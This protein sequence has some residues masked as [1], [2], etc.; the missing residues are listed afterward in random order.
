[1]GFFQIQQLYSC[2]LTEK[3]SPNFLEV[4]PQNLTVNPNYKKDP[5]SGT[6]ERF[7]LFAE[8]ELISAQDTI[9]DEM[10]KVL[11][12]QIG[13]VK[14]SESQ[15][16]N[17]CAKRLKKIIEENWKP[18]KNH[19][20]MHSS[21][22][23]SRIISA[24][25]TEFFRKYGP[26]WLGKTIF[27]CSSKEGSAFKRIMKLEGWDLNQY[28]TIGNNK[29]RETI[30]SILLDFPNAWRRCNGT[31]LNP[32]NPFVFFPEAAH[33]SRRFP[34]ENIQSWTGLGANELFEHFARLNL[35]I[36]PSAEAVFERAYYSP[37]VASR[38]IIGEVIKPFS[39]T[40]LLSLAIQSSTRIGKNIRLKLA[41][42][43]DEQLG[44]LPNSNPRGPAFDCNLPI[45]EKI[46]KK[47]L[48]DYRKSWYGKKVKPE[49]SWPESNFSGLALGPR[50][51]ASERKNQTLRRLTLCYWVIASL[52]EYLLEQGYQ[53]KISK[54]K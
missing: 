39:D 45:P 35:D 7:T 10:R 30:A 54:G 31:F 47:A 33:R 53:I 22:W 41:Q 17:L 36:G 43:V 50:V 24:Y 44:K 11:D 48:Q 23:D 27:L 4:L 34:L 15:C 1:M 51:P 42:V 26:E 13:S 2:L 28:L 38:P 6:R 3:I 52:C 16:L 46:V 32:L 5:A 20:I 25:I 8:V 37:A 40:N 19:I 12:S 29:N 18:E 49:I 9:T 14:M 21:G